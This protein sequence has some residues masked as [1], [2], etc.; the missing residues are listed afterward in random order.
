MFLRRISLIR[1]RSRGG[2]VQGLFMTY[3]GLAAVLLLLA[4]VA[5]IPAAIVY[6]Q[7]SRR[8]DRTARML[9]AQRE[10]YLALQERYN[11]M[12]VEIASAKEEGRR[13]ELAALESRGAPRQGV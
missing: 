5:A 7:T 1:N 8:D 12:A 4:V 6:T 10:M 9:E 3:R 11:L 13:R 2:E